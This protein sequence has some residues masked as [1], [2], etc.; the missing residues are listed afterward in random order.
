MTPHL[1]GTR[2]VY[3]ADREAVIMAL[4]VKAQGS[5]SPVDWLVRSQHNRAFRGGK[6]AVGAGEWRPGAR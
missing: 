2:R 1:P 5:G 6:K 3:V 4:M